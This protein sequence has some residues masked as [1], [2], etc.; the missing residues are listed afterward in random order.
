MDT[1]KLPRPQES[2]ADYIK[3]IRISDGMT[4]FELAIAAGIHSRSIGKIERGLTTRLNRKT[5]RG[6]AGGLGIPQ[7]Y[8]E[9]VE[10]GESVKG[11]NS[12]RFCP[13]CW[14]PGANPDPL[15]S[16]IRA[17][18]CYLCGMQLQTS[19][20]HCGELVVSLKYK[21]CPMCGKSYKEKSQNC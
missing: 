3:R 19:C 16:Q 7:E 10:R 4:Q 14:T 20:T 9:A 15:W 18:F 21:F 17:K 8:L 1:L 2:L 13:Q 12:I 5:L 6:L 11:V